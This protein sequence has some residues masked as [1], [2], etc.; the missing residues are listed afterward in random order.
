[1]DADRRNEFHQFTRMNS[2]EFVQFVSRVFSNQYICVRLSPSV[3]TTFSREFLLT[4]AEFGVSSAPMTIK[5]QLKSPNTRD[6]YRPPFW[7]LVVN[8]RRHAG[9]WS[10]GSP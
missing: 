3:V 7:L 1:M 10:S 2:G 9:G 8:I 4:C 5:P 6:A